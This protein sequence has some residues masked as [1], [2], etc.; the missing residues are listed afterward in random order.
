MTMSK[1][2]YD[3]R[4]VTVDGQRMLTLAGAM[5]YPRSMPSLWPSLMR[6][7]KAAGLNTVETYVFWNLHERERGVYDFSGRLD[8]RRW[9]ELAAAEG[10]SV[11]L[12][13]GPY[14]CA[15]TNY[16]GFPPWLRDVEGMTMRTWNAPFMREMETWSRFL[17]DYLR[18]MF[19]PAGGPIIMAQFENEFNNVATIYKEDGQRY[20]QWCVQLADSLNFGVPCVMCAGGARGAI[21]TINA[22]YGHLQLGRHWREHPDQPALWTEF[23]TGWYDT[24]G[25]PH[26]ERKLE[27]IAYASARFIAAGGTG[28][29]YFMLHGGTNF[30]RDCMYLQTASYD[31]DGLIDEFGLETTKLRHLTRL[32]AALNDYADVLLSADRPTPEILGGSEANLVGKIE[33]T[34]GGG[35][36]IETLGASV[37]T[38]WTYKKGK[39]QLTFLCNDDAAV[40]ATVT[41]DKRTFTLAPQSVVLLGDGKPLFDSADVR[42]SDVIVR[43]MKPAKPLTFAAWTEPMPDDWPDSAAAM[44]VADKPV[45]QLRLTQDCT[46]YCWYVTALKIG[47]REAGRGKLTFSGAAD[48]IYVYV[49]G[50]RVAST[51]TPLA[52]NRNLALYAQD[53]AILGPFSLTQDCSFAQEFELNLSAGE[54]ELAVLCN[55]MGL[56][57]GEWMLGMYNM[58]NERKGLWGD[59][60]WKGRRLKGPWLM[61]PGLLGEHLGAFSTPG[62]LLTWR[63]QRKPFTGMR[64]LRATFE[65]PRGDAPL[66]LDMIGMTKG[67]IYLNGQCV[68]RY[69]TQGAAGRDVFEQFRESV[70]HKFTP[71]PTQRYYNLPADWIDDVNTLTILE[72]TGGDT[73]TLRVVQRK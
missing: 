7:A 21:E 37:Q 26:H 32:H 20:L 46:D 22:F 47:L 58:V 62:L 35:S 10:L 73:E 4:A 5:H 24:Y 61:Q 43:T 15:E 70:V 9:C 68:G 55:A 28:L 38:A 67:M 12:R 8:L 16:G 63:P 51:P 52:E 71:Q 14:V 34:G 19:A 11:I 41:F 49:D 56:V 50:K 27:D 25:Y 72:E 31:F 44:Y 1:I 3:H 64:W 23:Y 65:R 40:A 6:Q 69:W 42:K 13:I 48:M 30:G 54:H 45:E 36:T 17:V 2:S 66:A 60:L 18:P 59:V 57:K 53:P 29:N 33:G 39:R